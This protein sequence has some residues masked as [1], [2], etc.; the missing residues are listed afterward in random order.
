[1]LEMAAALA[2]AFGAG[3]PAP[4]VTGEF[5]AGDVRH[6]HASP[7]RARLALGFSAGVGFAAG[8]SEFAHAPLRHP[9]EPAY[10]R[11]GV[12]FSVDSH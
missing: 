1:V 10:D 12:S 3:A 7:E 8:M 9:P 4:E 6:V 2:S 11:P 5:R